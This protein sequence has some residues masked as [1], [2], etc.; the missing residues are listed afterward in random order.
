MAFTPISHTVPQ[1]HNNGSPASGFVLKAYS[2]GTLNNISMATDSTGDTTAATISLNANGYPE[3]SGA[4]VIP[5]INEKYKLALYA[6]QAAA[7]ADTSPIWIPDTIPIGGELGAV[8]QSISTTTSLTASDINNHIVV[9]GT[10]TITLPDVAGSVGS[11]FVFTTRNGGT[12]LVTFDGKDAETINGALTLVLFPGDSCMFTSSSTATDEWSTTGLEELRG[13]KAE[14]GTTYTFVSGDHDGLVTT[15]NASAIAGT[16]PQAGAAFPDG[17]YTT[18]SNIGVGTLTI[19]PTT[20]TIDENATLVL[21]SGR[22]LLITSDGSNYRSALANTEGWSLVEVQAASTSPSINFETGI[23]STGS[24]YKIVIADLVPSTSLSVG[25][26]VRNVSTYRTSGYDWGNSELRTPT[27]VSA[28]GGSGSDSKMQIMNR[29][30]SGSELLISAIIDIM[31][32]ADSGSKTTIYTKGI[33][34]DSATNIE[35]GGGQY[36]TAEANN[37]IKVLPNTGTFITGT[38]SLYKLSAN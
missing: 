7:D 13:V 36:G 38:F 11:G 3:V 9:T 14:T 23:D 28:Y 2:S 18:V 15:S 22:S 31:N 10:N 30:I 19:T 37:G 32:P 25:V 5:Y 12:G 16:L 24:M 34:E 33:I 4:V 29:S 6:T 26:Q 8:T 35:Y 1:Y 21:G 20:S 17:W 27:P